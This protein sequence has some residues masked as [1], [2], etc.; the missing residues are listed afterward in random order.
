MTITKLL[1]LE[2]AA[3][4]IKLATGLDFKDTPAGLHI[5]AQRLK[6]KSIAKL[7]AEIKAQP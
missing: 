3:Q 5:L 7:I 1:E 6:G 4:E 2:L